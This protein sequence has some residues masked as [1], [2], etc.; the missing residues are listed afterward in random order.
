MTNYEK[1]ARAERE[2]IALLELVG[3]DCT[4]SAGSKGMWD[5]IA[6][7]RNHVRFIQ[8]KTEG[9]MTPVELEK[10]KLYTTPWHTTKEVWTRMAG[11]RK[12]QERWQQEIVE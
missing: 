1:G 4:R 3:Y 5:I 7:Y 8:V 12:L 9:A 10:I 6:V 11:K 2:A